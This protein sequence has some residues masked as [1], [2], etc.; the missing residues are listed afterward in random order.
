MLNRKSLCKSAGCLDKII[1]NCDIEERCDRFYAAQCGAAAQE[2]ES[3][4]EA[5]K[6]I[7]KYMTESYLSGHR[8]KIL[9]DALERGE[10]P[11]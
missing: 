1:E 9:E 3:I 2:K 5:R 7:H 8:L 10:M 6:E 11:D 4:S